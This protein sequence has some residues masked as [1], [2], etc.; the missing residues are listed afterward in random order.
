MQ[1]RWH[2]CKQ[3]RWFWWHQLT[4]K[5]HYALKTSRAYYLHTTASSTKT[6]FLSMLLQHVLTLLY[7]SRRCK[8]LCTHRFGL[9]H[10]SS[11]TYFDV[12]S[13]CLENCDTKLH[14]KRARPTSL[15]HLSNVRCQQ[16]IFVNKGDV[17]IKW[18]IMQE[19]C[20]RQKMYVHTFENLC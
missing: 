4:F 15:F 14:K 6:G 8:K 13:Q 9:V 3:K 7:K 12:T 5:N 17:Y 11:H 18:V 2:L 20:S 19:G 1:T 10:G 16:G